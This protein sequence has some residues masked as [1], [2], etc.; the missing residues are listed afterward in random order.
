[1]FPAMTLLFKDNFD[2]FKIKHDTTKNTLTWQK[3]NYIQG[4]R[5]DFLLG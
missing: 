5:L 3:V 2:L 4:M 1:M